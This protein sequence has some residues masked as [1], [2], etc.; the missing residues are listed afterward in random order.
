MESVAKINATMYASTVMKIILQFGICHTCVLDNDR[1]FFGVCCKALTFLQIN[2]HV[3][4]GGCHNPMLVKRLNQYLNKGLWIMTNERNSNRFAL[5][6][7]LHLIYAWN[8]W[9]MPDT[10]ILHCMV[11]L[12][13]E[14]SFPIDFSIG[15]HAELYSAAGTDE[16]YSKQLPTYLSCCWAVAKLLLKQHYSWYRELINSQWWDPRIYSIEDI[17]FACWSTCSD[18]KHG[19]VDKPMHPFTGPCQ[20]VKLLPGASYKLEFFSNHSQKEKNVP[21][22]SLPTPQNTY[23]LSL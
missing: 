6:A 8:S 23:I 2:H 17:V 15:K 4:S 7:I 19:C 22:I 1:K 14:F 18:S 5:E 20:I 16:S 13:Q 9:P 11:A 10:D 3:L 21:P 12:G